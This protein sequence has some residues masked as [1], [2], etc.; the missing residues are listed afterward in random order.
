[1]DGLCLYQ[2]DGHILAGRHPMGQAERGR[3]RV[4]ALAV[5]AKQEIRSI[6]R[7]VDATYQASAGRSCRKSH[8]REICRA[9]PRS[10]VDLSGQE[11]A[12]QP[13]VCG[14]RVSDNVLT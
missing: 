13:D 3:A 11:I 5:L 10:G 2:G 4:W 14:S 6:L 1:M 12:V 7:V 9:E 8:A